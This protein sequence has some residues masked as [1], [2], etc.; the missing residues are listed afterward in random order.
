MDPMKPS[1]ERGSATPSRLSRVEDLKLSK[2]ISGGQFGADLAGVRTAKQC[3]IP[4][5]GTMPYKCMT[6]FGPRPEYIA[7]YGMKMSKSSSYADRTA[8]NVK[9]SDGTIRFAKSFSSPG[10]LCTL[11]AIKRHRKPFFD[12]D[13]KNLSVLS[14]DPCIDWIRQN[15][16]RVLNVA[17]NSTQEVGILTGAYLERL[18]I[19]LGHR[20]GGAA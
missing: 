11:R 14:L 13:L 19:A 20:G 12:V 4:T 15:N 7:E 3:G 16:I 9:D 17:G 10:E 6:I 1:C 8:A 18:F 2:V 5:G